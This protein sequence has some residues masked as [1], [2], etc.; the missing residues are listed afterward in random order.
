MFRK[1]FRTGSLQLV[2]LVLLLLTAA[3]T[4]KGST[5]PPIVTQD[6]AAQDPAAQELEEVKNALLTQTAEVGITSTSIPTTVST[7]EPTATSVPPSPT[8]IPTPTE[9]PVLY[10]DVP[11]YFQDSVRRAIDN[12]WLEA[13]SISVF[14]SRRPAY[15]YQFLVAVRNI[16]FPDDP[17]PR[18]VWKFRD[19]N[20]DHP[21]TIR[22]LD[23]NPD[24][25][26]EEIVRRIAPPIE[27]LAGAGL[28]YACDPRNDPPAV[29]PLTQSRA[30]TIAIIVTAGGGV[31]P[32]VSPGDLVYLDAPYD[33]YSPYLKFFKEELGCNEPGTNPPDF[34]HPALPTLQLEA[35]VWLDCFDRYVASDN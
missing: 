23:E 5:P 17:L 11:W 30:N 16:L 28:L 6:P 21:D 35:A 31:L 32:E 4:K 33:R 25:I 19:L 1:I 22:M 20:P 9:T 13:E 2:L 7:P 10:V 27:D 12:G 14:G 29:C 18:A 15:G 34:I 8:P 24:L 26:T 3:C